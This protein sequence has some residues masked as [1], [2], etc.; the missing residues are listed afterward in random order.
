MPPGN[1]S[2]RERESHHVYIVF[3]A[4]DSPI[5]TKPYPVQNHP[6]GLNILNQIV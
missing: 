1:P 2:Q 6:G 4:L 5:F 3:T